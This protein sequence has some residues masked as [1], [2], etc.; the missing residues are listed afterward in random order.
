MEKL[1]FSDLYVCSYTPSLGAL[2]AARTTAN[3]SQI[4]CL[5]PSLLIVD[6]PDA[7]FQGVGEEV[8]VMR[9]VSIPMTGLVS[10]KAT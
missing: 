5:S 10:E 9:T 6:Q 4:S 1:Y 2:I 7:K 8:E 3:D